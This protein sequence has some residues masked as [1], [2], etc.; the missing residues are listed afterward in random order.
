MEPGTTLQIRLPDT[1]LLASAPSSILNNLFVFSPELVLVG[2]LVFLFLFDALFPKARSG[3][4]PLIVV[5]IGCI[6]GAWDSVM[7]SSVPGPAFYGMIANDAWTLFFRLFFFF[8]CAAGLYVAYGSKEV[9]LKSR[10]EFSM[11]LVCVTFGLSLMAISTNV[12]LLYMGIE[13]VSI[14]SFVMAGFARENLRSNEASLKYLVFGALSSAL[15]LYGFSLLYGYTGSLQYQ[16]IAKGLAQNSANPPFFILLALVMIYAGFAYKISAFPLHFWTPDVYEGSP[17][18]VATFF[19]VGPKAAG[20]AALIRF[21]L[22]VLGTKSGEGQWTLFAQNILLPAVAAISAITMI[23]GNLSALAQ[24]SAKRILAYSSIAHVGYMLMGLVT[25]NRT[26]LSA[27][28][29][30]LVVYCA[31]NVGA[32]WVVSVVSNIRGRDDLDAFRGMGWTNPVLG[33]CMGIFLFSLTGIPLFGGFIGKFLLFGAILQT[34]GFLWLALLGVLNS[35][36]SLYYYLKI[37]KAMWLDRPTKADL[38]VPALS[39][40]H[41]VGI[42]GLAIPTI[43]LGLFFSPVLRFVEY[44]VSNF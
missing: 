37:L 1:T 8:S 36:V 24:T 20:F 30:Y 33:V 16:E 12:L 23:V 15:M 11:L 29:F 5:V 41:A 7:V 40:Y 31:M 19:S 44:S 9:E 14:V 28:L 21:V 42:I 17:T 32:F 18:P 34:P 39:L 22:V 6:W 13:T 43:L 3:F 27:I 25:L 35:V 10:S 2:I 26:G 38:G 4:I